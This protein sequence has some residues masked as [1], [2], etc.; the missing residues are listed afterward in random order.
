MSLVALDDGAHS[1]AFVQAL[2]LGRQAQTC[3]HALYQGWIDCV[4]AL[5]AAQ[6]AGVFRLTTNLQQTAARRRALHD[7]LRLEGE[8]ASLRAQAGKE[9]QL[10]CQ[11][12]LNLAL[13]RVKAEL[14]IAKNCL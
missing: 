5:Q 10:A 3:L 6:Y 4:L 14:H 2:V 12:E 7:C 11:V 9:T 13:A 8:A 1:Q